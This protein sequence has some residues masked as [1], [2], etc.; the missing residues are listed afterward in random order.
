Q[1][2]KVSQFRQIRTR[3]IKPGFVFNRADLDRFSIT[4]E[5][6]RV[7]KPAILSSFEAVPI[8]SVE[9]AGDLGRVAEAEDDFG[10]ELQLADDLMPHRHQPDGARV[11]EPEI[12]ETH[13]PFEKRGDLAP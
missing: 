5:V 2:E 12:T 11:L 8:A 4:E 1:F 13:P 7:G 3:V 10:S 6:D 9:R